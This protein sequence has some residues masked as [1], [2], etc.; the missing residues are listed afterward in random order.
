MRKNL[1]TRGCKIR[2]ELHKSVA[3]IRREWMYS[4]WRW[5]PSR[6]NWS[7]LISNLATPTM[8]T[9]HRRW[10]HWLWGTHWA[11]I[12]FLPNSIQAF[13]FSNMMS[14]FTRF[15]PLV[16]WLYMFSQL[17][18]DENEVAQLLSASLLF[19]WSFYLCH[20]CTPPTPGQYVGVSG[21]LVL[22]WRANFPI[23]WGIW[24]AM[25]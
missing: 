9:N 11:K 10:W 5:K 1:C 24:Q 12:I 15:C 25:Q 16:D 23:W 8:S 21:G 2:A 14:K 22:T 4:T 17:K 7:I 20:S 6:Y 3:I 19:R 18:W 13:Y